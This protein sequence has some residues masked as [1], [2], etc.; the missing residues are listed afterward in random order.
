MKYT[1]CII[2]FRKT[3]GEEV[4][5]LHLGWFHLTCGSSAVLAAL[6]NVADTAESNYK[7][8]FPKLCPYS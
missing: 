2:H 4:M 3:E 8:P 5:V 6:Q 7:E 1:L